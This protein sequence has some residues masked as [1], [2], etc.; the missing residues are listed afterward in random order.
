MRA[1]IGYINFPKNIFKYVL[2][3]ELSKYYDEISLTSD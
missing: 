3:G 1:T 2:Q